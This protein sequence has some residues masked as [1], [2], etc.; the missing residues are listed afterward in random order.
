MEL[1]FELRRELIRAYSDW[2]DRVIVRLE[3][4]AA[5]QSRSDEDTAPPWTK[6]RA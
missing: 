1:E 5:E 6:P 4:R 2:T 3:K